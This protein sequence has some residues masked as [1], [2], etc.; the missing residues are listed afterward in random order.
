M[1][2]KRLTRVEGCYGLEV[3]VEKESEENSCLIR[4]Y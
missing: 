2:E 4:V 1:E 3:E